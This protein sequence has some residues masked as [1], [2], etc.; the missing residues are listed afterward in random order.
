MR[1]LIWTIL[2]SLLSACGGEADQTA[3]YRPPPEPEKILT[4]EQTVRELVSAYLDKRL[5]EYYHLVATI[6]KEAKSLAELQVEFAPSSSDLV[7]DYLFKF[8]SFRI[9]STSVDGDSALVYVTSH[10]PNVERVIR[11][12]AVVERSVG[13]D[14]ELLT[15]LSLLNER[16]RLGGGPREENQT[17]YFLVREPRGWRAV[18]GWADRK[19]FLEQMRADSS[20]AG[21]T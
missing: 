21:G 10:S 3:T 7:T 15:K 16:L 9:D 2:I 12:A 1:S 8:T 17:V 13:A 11:E 14:A 6:D 4:P 18:V 5:G 20:Q 19:E